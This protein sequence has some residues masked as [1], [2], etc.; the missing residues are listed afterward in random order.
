MLFVII[1]LQSM[2]IIGAAYTIFLA[3]MRGTF[4]V[5]IFIT[6]TRISFIMMKSLIL[7]TSIKRMKR[8]KD[9]KKYCLFYNFE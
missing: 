3:Q 5:P 7:I 1:I 8:W 4:I 6:T 9:E 2:G